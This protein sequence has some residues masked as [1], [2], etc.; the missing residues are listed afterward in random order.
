M[1]AL[2]TSAFL[3]TDPIKNLLDYLLKD[4]KILLSVKTENKIQSL[5]L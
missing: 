5:T 2:I 1:E 3:T 4:S